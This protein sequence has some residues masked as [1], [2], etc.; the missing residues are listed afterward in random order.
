[1]DKSKTRVMTKKTKRVVFDIETE[2]FSQGFLD[3]KTVAD[4]TNEAPKMRIACVYEEKVDKYHYF[5]PTQAEA[6]IKILSESEEVISFNGKEF[7]VLVL[8]KHYGLDHNNIPA[9]GTHVDIH[10]IMTDITG[11]RVSLNKAVDLNFGERKHT[12]GKSMVDLDMEKLKEAC[13]S[14]VKQTYRLWQLH[15]KGSLECPKK[16]SYLSPGSDNFGPGHHMPDVCPYCHDVGSLE[17][18][19][20]VNEEYEDM[21]EG[22]QADYEAGLFGTAYCST[23]YASFDWEK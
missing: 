20:D 7:D 15:D 2:P 12:S 18:D 5:D 8:K 10:E 4:K 11:Y 14:D 21:T 13:R 19:D 17:F 3:A 23:C 6:L 22:Q 16:K 1:M 9:K